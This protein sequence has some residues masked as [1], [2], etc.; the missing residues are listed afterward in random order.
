MMRPPRIRTR[1]VRSAGIDTHESGP[2][3]PDTHVLRVWFTHTT[4]PYAR[5]GHAAPSVRVSR[6]DVPTKINKTALSR[7]YARDVCSFLLLLDPGVFKPQS[8][9]QSKLENG[10]FRAVIRTPGRSPKCTAHAH[11]NVWLSFPKLAKALANGDPVSR[12]PS[13]RS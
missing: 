4:A 1:T 13:A 5:V 9:V 2:Y 6:Y 8:N 7:P 3:V 11:T 10:P 12:S